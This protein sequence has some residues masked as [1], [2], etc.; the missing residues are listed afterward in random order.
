MRTG[1]PLP[2]SSSLL[3]DPHSPFIH[4]DL[5]WLQFNERVLAEAH[6]SKNP[7]LE[8]T[9]FLAI[10]SSNLDE[11]FM[12]RY[13]SLT[14]SIQTLA[15]H[16]RTQATRLIRVR[17]NILKSVHEF[18]RKQSHIFRDLISQLAPEGIIFSQ[19]SHPEKNTFSAG[20]QIF[21]EEILPNLSPPETFVPVKLN[22]LSNLQL[23][24][25][26]QE[27]TWFK[28][29]RQLSPMYTYW[30]P[31]SKQLYLFFL[32]ELIYFHLGQ[33][34]RFDS[35]PLLVRL[36]RDGDFTVDINEEDTESIPDIVRVGL[37]T[38]EKGR[39]VRIQYRGK[40]SNRFLKVSIDALK[41]TPPQ[42][43]RSPTTLCLNGIALLKARIPQP[44]GARTSLSYPPL[45]SIIP[46]PFRNPEHIFERLNQ[47]DLLLHHPY[48]SFDA[49]V[50]W[51]RSACSDPHVTR[52]EQ[53][54]YRMDV[55]SPVIEVLKNA[56]HAKKIR[57]IIEL[58]ARF[59]ELNNLRLA[60]ELRKAGIEVAFG[61]G[62]LKLHG[63]VALITR[64]IGNQERLYAHLSTGNYNAKTAR[65]YTDLAILTSNQDICKD[66]RYF[67]DTVWSGK[68]PTDFKQLVSAP[69][70]LHRRLLSLIQGEIEAALKGGKARIV[71]KV[72]ALV[73]ES[74]IKH[75]YRASQAGVRV[76]LIVRGACSL[77][78]GVRGLSDNIRVIS[79]VDRFLEHSRIY[80]FSHAKIIYLSS[81]DWMPRNFF[82]RLELAF[83]I[84]DP[85]LY[86]FIETFIIP[87]YLSDTVKAR[88]LTP[89][90]KWKLRSSA[91]SHSK[92]IRGELLRSDERAIRSQ[93]LL[94]KAA[95]HEYEGTPL[96]RRNHEAR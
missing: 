86:R 59:D 70:R 40:M 57:V 38:R 88:E 20:K 11:F 53:T 28:I 52:I 64:V 33:A 75:L 8:R 4:R 44:T 1:L 81:A 89:E 76:D 48:D 2:T 93:F 25:I 71:A 15:R 56:A 84:L 9:N 51:I 16:E 63:K 5:S 91:A 31:T 58:R 69:T 55:L 74:V 24:A 36:T 37:G 30:N 87:L 19:S 41:L 18:T 61:F 42:A 77:I 32:D 29:P 26:Y 82:S 39:P 6:S 95:V 65:Q 43:F 3:T 54:I 90:G 96:G 73:D 34:F 14:R 67:F 12:I 46:K 60:D 45:Q 22:T 27:N 47:R 23:G 10:S 83:P 13:A 94:E 35:Q 7:L 21:D 92:L 17:N 49:Y 68:I 72:N 79:V 78:P 62:K 50:S 80:S 66:V 85:D